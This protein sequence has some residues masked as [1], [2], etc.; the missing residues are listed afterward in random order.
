MGFQ[1]CHRQL[2][3]A[4]LPKHARA[5]L[6]TYLVLIH[7]DR[8]RRRSLRYN[9]KSHKLFRHYKTYRMLIRLRRWQIADQATSLI[10]AKYAEEPRDPE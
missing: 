3:T 8:K 9:D 5:V 6:L 4:N 1:K 10:R 7:N 2:L